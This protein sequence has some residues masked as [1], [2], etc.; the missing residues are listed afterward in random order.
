MN[1]GKSARDKPVQ[2][3]KLKSQDNAE[4]NSKVGKNNETVGG[5]MALL[6]K[7]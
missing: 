3:E 6:P 4:S 5:K 2:L 1:T 7:I